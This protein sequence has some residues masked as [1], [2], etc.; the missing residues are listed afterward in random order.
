MEKQKKYFKINLFL[1]LMG[2]VF[3]FGLS[4]IN[5]NYVNENNKF[6]RVPNN[7]KLINLG[8][9]HGLYGIKYPPEIN[10]FNFS[11]SS[12]PF[13]Y[14]LKILKKNISKIQENG[15]VLIPISIFSFYQG[16]K[17]EELNDNYYTFLDANEVYLGDSRK[18]FTIKYFSLFY[19]SKEI[20][21]VAKYLLTS[22]KNKT[23]KPQPL[24][25][26]RNLSLNEKI[27]EAEKT[28]KRHLG[29]DDLNCS[30]PP[31]ISFGYLS[32]ILEFC[33]K[34]NLK[35]VLITTPQSYLYNERITKINYEK[36][37]YSHI[38]KL[39][40]IFKF[41]YLDYSHDNRFINNLNLFSDDD[42][43]NEKGAEIFTEILLNDLK[44]KSI[45]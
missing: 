14:D 34:N 6:L 9:S 37:I 11:V 4:Y 33:L 28:T 1:I 40:E 18:S 19:N 29:I 35:P 23:F 32:N 20:I 21:P 24:K 25:W 17:I 22:L 41:D 43:L 12:Q 36:R 30:Q 13:Y 31:D 5:R 45:L 7:L 39:N 10:A 2:V 38:K 15:V 16:N 42:H 26:P 27:N 8:S 3:I 44:L